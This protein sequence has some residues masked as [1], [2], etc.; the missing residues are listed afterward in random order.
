MQR[1]LHNKTVPSWVTPS[2][3]E[4]MRTLKEFSFDV[5]Y[6]LYKREEKSRLQG[7]VLLKQI[8]RNIEQS[9]DTS[10]TPSPKLMVYSAVSPPRVQVLE[11]AAFS[12]PQI[13]ACS[14]FLN[15]YGHH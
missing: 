9:L 1:Q 8:L 14:M 12:V 15:T 11:P 5:D 7:G 13:L 2:V 4:H 6:R 10:P 3:M